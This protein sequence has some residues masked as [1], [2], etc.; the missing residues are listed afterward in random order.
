MRRLI[1]LTL[2]A[3]LLITGALATVLSI[4][5]S[6]ASSA[7]VTM[8]LSCS[9]RTGVKPTSYVLTCADANETFTSLHWSDWGEATAYATGLYRWNDCTPTCV[10]G[11]WHQRP[12]TL[13]AWRIRD[14]RYT[15]LSSDVASLPSNIALRAYPG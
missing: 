12:V 4:A 11:K 8:V 15:L 10:A 3:T 6:R 5:E 14:H 9:S 7:S 2:V 13:R 1:P